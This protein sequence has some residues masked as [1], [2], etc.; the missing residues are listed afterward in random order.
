MSK[1]VLCW[2][3][4][5]IWKRSHQLHVNSHHQGCEPLAVHSGGNISWYGVKNVEGPLSCRTWATYW[6]D[7]KYTPEEQ[8][9]CLVIVHATRMLHT[10]Y[11]SFKFLS[12][13]LKHLIKGRFP[14]GKICKVALTSLQPPT[15]QYH[16][17]CLFKCLLQGKINSTRQGFVLFITMDTVPQR[18]ENRVRLRWPSL[19]ERLKSWVFL[20]GQ[21]SSQW[22]AH[23]HCIHW[24][25]LRTCQKCK[26]TEGRD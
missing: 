13:Q 2:F 14:A 23:T 6:L 22:S 4:I 3:Y 16:Q 17:V 8:S 11:F 19:H 24:L 7:R 20:P 1:T 18:R 26:A 9:S 10:K 12:I 25:P 21:L 5:L 15:P